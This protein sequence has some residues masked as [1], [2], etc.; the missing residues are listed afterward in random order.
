MVPVHKKGEADGPQSA[1]KGSRVRA[2]AM[3]MGS[4][5]VAIT[6]FYRALAVYSGNLTF[7]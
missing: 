5:I 3:E 2:L 7:L 6:A 4:N 1:P